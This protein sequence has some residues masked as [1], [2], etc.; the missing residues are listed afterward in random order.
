MAHRAGKEA[1]YQDGYL[2]RRPKV[3]TE[4]YHERYVQGY[5]YGHRLGTLDRKR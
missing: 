3:F 4:E 2:G 1:G 5:G